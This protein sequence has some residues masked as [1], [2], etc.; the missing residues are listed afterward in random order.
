MA[1]MGINFTSLRD[2]VRDFFNV[3]RGRA[4]SEVIRTRFMDGARVDGIHVLQLMCAMLIA[5][6]GLNLNS[7]EAV[8]GA[9]LIC[10]LMGS[11]LAIA[12]AIATVDMSALKE[13]VV[14]LITQVV[15]CLLT[16]TIY[17][18]VSPITTTTTYLLLT[19]QPTVWDVILALVGGFAGGLGNSRR[20]TPST[21]IAGV[22]VATS[23]MP[24]LCAA[25]FGIATRDFGIMLSAFYEFCLNVVFIAFGAELILVALKMPLCADLDG[26]G[27]VTEVEE[28][29]AYERFEHLRHRLIVGSLIF[30]IPCAFFSWRVVYQQMEVSGN[31]LG[32]VDTYNTELC[33]LELSAVTPD[34]VSYRIGE[35]DS[36]VDGRLEKRTVATV[37]TATELSEEQKESLTTLIRLNVRD[38]CEVSEVTFEVQPEGEVIGDEDLPSKEVEAAE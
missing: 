14:G 22:A 8:I 32:A 25:S 23:L 26:D 37:V 18:I 33:T 27:I 6:I 7:T 9:M 13:C 24:P 20:D 34:L 3:N 19:S 35:E 4:D 12:C 2:M 5:S 29:E 11:V 15:V 16:S 21:L 38:I 10:P 31:L 28:A 36:F 1:Q 17:F 30:A